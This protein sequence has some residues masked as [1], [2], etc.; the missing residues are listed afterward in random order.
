MSKREIERQYRRLSAEERARF[1]DAARRVEN[2]FPP[3]RAIERRSDKN[4]PPTLGDYFDLRQLV[5]ALRQAREARGL[6]LADVQAATGIDRSALS[7]L[8]RGENLN[9][10]ISTLAR[11]A[12]AV[13]QRIDVRLREQSEDAVRQAE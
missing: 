7:R 4:L 2:E 3:G 9:P 11:Y 5:A 13:G 6:S 1:A 12:G 10:T 8:E